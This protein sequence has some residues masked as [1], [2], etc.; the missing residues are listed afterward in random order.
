MITRYAPTA[1][2]LML[3]WSAAACSAP[4][5]DGGGGEGGGEPPGCKASADCAAT[6]ETPLCDVPSGECLALPAGWEIGVTDGTPASVAFA[7][8]YEPD[9]PR[10]PTDLAFNPSKP[11]ELW[12]V[13]RLD[14]SAIII[15]NP[16]TPE[17]S[18]ERKRDPAAAHFMAS[19]PAIAFGAVVPQWGQ[20]FAV[21]GDS[22]NGGD[23]FMG[24]ALFTADL[25]VF[26]KSTPGGLGS[27]LDMLHSTPF[28]RGI[29]HVDAS[30][31][32]A[33]NADKGSLDKYN[34]QLDH[35]PGYDDHSDGEVYRYV[36]ALVAGVNGVPSHLVYSPQDFGLYVAD[37]G[38]K[39]I[40][41]LDTTTGTVGTSFSGFEPVA[42]RKKVLGATFVDVVPPGILEAPSGIEIHGEL[43]YVSDNATSR[44]Y[45]F[46]LAGTLIRQLDTGFPPGTLAG[47]T[48]GP[49]DGLIY[50]TNLLTGQVHRIHPLY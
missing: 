16:G 31:Y 7:L 45:V 23:D 27:H 8:I 14:G 39:R 22:D 19:P 21:C 46:D 10:Q 32:F 41:K 47:F 26:A 18:W 29:A 37:T 40:A 5:G 20:T 30:V 33:F 3:C 28:C 25:N 9:K 6:P 12:V 15:Q 38:H 43:L 17:V 49:D 24:P 50:F 42:V 13:N 11:T 1:G 34:F 35:G 2:V 48:F 36:E 44:F 4:G